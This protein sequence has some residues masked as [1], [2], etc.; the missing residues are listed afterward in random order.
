VDD[1]IISER[2]LLR[3]IQQGMKEHKA[4]KTIKADLITD[5][6]LLPDEL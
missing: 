5:L 2:E 3:E 1:H 6:L 4:G